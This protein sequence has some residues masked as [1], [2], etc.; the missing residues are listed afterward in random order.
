L[1]G[2]MGNDLFFARLSQELLDFDATRDTW[3]P[4]L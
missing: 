2:G 4:L 3:V 1:S